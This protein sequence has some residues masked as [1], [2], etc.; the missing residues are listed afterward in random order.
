MLSMKLFGAY[1]VHVDGMVPSGLWRRSGAQLLAL[2]A[3]Y[4]DRDIRATWVAELLWPGTGSLD[5]LD[6]CLKSAR[7]ALGPEG[8]RL[9]LW[10]KVIRLRTDGAEIDVVTFDG[11]LRAHHQRQETEALRSAIDLYR[12]PL[13]HSWDEG[14]ALLERKTRKEQYLDAL[15]MLARRFQAAGD[16]ASA[17]RYLRCLVKEKPSLE[18]AWCELMM[19]LVELEERL[20][21]IE[22][23]KRYQQ[24]AHRISDGK[25]RPP[26]VMTQLLTHIYTRV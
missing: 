1:E 12:G 19:A 18:S 9:E 11:A 4:H 24:H 8:C 25:L 2:L 16:H 20:E 7:K 13:L 17:V 15:Q 5:S 26:P 21:A 10:N 6:Q 22:V 14:W 3:L 23:Y